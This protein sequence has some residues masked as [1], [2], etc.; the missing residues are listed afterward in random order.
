MN[1]APP[2]MKGA[3]GEAGEDEVA[4][5]NSWFGPSQLT[6]NVSKDSNKKRR[7]TGTRVQ[8]SLMLTVRG[9]PQGDES[10]AGEK[11]EK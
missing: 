10:P 2:M 7:Q 3:I 9:L 6:F 5:V 1:S 4:Q 8:D 11:P